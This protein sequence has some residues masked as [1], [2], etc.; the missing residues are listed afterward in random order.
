MN[1]EFDAGGDRGLD[2]L[3]STP[4]SRQVNCTTLR[5]EHR[6][7]IHH[8]TATADPGGDTGQLPALL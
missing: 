3:A 2:I 5:T 4:Y 1:M 6:G 8:S 7:G